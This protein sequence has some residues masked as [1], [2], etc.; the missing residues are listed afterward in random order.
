MSVPF[1]LL[2][3][4]PFSLLRHYLGGSAN[5]RN[6][7]HRLHQNSSR[8]SA[9]VAKSSLE[10]ITLVRTHA[11]I[12]IWICLKEPNIGLNYLVYL[13]IEAFR[14]SYPH[15]VDCLPVNVEIHVVRWVSRF[16]VRI[17]KADHV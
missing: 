5:R 10:S 17:L 8:R 11:A 12:K 1:S 7:P 4:V 9:K 2:F 16:I 3:A 15:S 6:I 13:S 14:N